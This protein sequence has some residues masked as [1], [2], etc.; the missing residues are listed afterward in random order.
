MFYR[1]HHS[2][3]PKETGKPYQQ[4]IHC[5]VS[6]IPVSDPHHFMSLY[7]K[8]VDDVSKYVTPKAILEKNAK[9]TDLVSTG[10]DGGVRLL[11]SNKLKNILARQHHAGLQ[12]FP[13]SVFGA[14]GTEVKD[15]WLMNPFSFD[16]NHID[17]AKSKFSIRGLGGVKLGDIE[18]S[19]I[20]QFHAALRD[21]ALPKSL[22]IETLHIIPVTEKNLLIIRWVYG[23]I[24]YYVSDSIRKEIEDAGCTGI[25]FTKPEDPFR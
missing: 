24:G 16:F 22:Q 9:L 2:A 25:A 7:L 3:N 15:Y 12:F 19:K 6:S 23:A 8:E 4:S 14:D 1:I 13:T 10:F 21:R 18:I 5:K 20:E 11:I 17:F